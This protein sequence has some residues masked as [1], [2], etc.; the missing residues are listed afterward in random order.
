MRATSG[1]R[2]E[3]T[4]AFASAS[5]QQRPGTVCAVPASRRSREEILRG[6]DD[7]DRTR[8]YPA[9]GLRIGRL[10]LDQGFAL[11]LHPSLPPADEG[12]LLRLYLAFTLDDGRE[13]KAFHAAEHEG[14]VPL[15]SLLGR[16]V[17]NARM[18]AD[19]GFILELDDGIK[20][21]AGS[22]DDRDCW[23]FQQPW[24]PHFGRP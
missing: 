16:H 2:R 22:L 21:V 11:E 4:R 20:L 7:R 23:E 18:T 19:A 13:R 14:L 8:V 3:A 5:K 6:L 24:L 9:E 1:S 15:F 12:A 10:W 17:A